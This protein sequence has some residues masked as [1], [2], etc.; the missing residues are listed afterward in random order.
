MYN[1]APNPDAIKMRIVHHLGST[2]AEKESDENVGF[3]LSNNKGGY[4]S[5]FSSPSSRF[6]GLFYFDPGEGRMYKFIENIELKGGNRANALR[7]SVYCIER[8]K[9]DVSESFFMPKHFDSLVYELSAENEFDLVL[10]CKETYDNREWGRHYNIFEKDGLLVV[11]FTKITDSRED[12]SS[13]ANEFSLFLAIGGDTT[14][15]NKNDFWTERHYGF[16]KARNSRP[17]SRHVYN[18]LKLKGNSFVFSMSKSQKGALSECAYV[19]N[20]LKKLKAREKKNFDEFLRKPAVKNVV[21]SNKIG[22]RE[23]LAYINALDSLNK[24]VI[25]EKGNHTILAGLPW[26][27]QAWARDALI[28]LKAISKIDHGLAGKIMFSWLRLLKKDGRLPNITGKSYMT[29]TGSAD[30]TGLLFLRVAEM[31]DNWK[32]GQLP[33][34]K[35]ALES[36]LRRLAKEYTKNSLE[37]N[38]PKETW[39]DSEFKGDTREGARLEIQ[40]LKL[41]MYDYAFKLTKNQKYNILKNVL[42]NEVRNDF[43][44]SGVL[45]DGLGDFTIRPN[46]FIAHYAYPGILDKDE[47][48]AC[49]EETL[50]KIWLG[51]GGFST[52]DRS[53]PL[54]CESSTGENPQSYHRGDSWFWINNLGALSLLKANRHKFDDFIRKVTEA[55]TEEILWKGCIGCHSEISDAK[56]LSS[57]GCFNQAWSNAVY[58]ELIEEIVR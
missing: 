53:S 20:N 3:L 1:P 25:S 39:M 56:E 2:S 9:G 16:D 54:Y 10:D 41:A 57:K 18:A 37:Y 21:H 11:E 29:G 23:K 47:W 31:T 33:I 55:S 30:A 24:L 40:A 15:Y 27:F 42:R 45:A 49:F 36:S 28:S 52:I 19:L 51:W 32:P 14:S 38:S 5:F 35:N 17:F 34:V 22:T 58:L 7:N 13:G 12:Q 26:F 8:E 4:C 6:Q 48:E 44:S 43:W 50:K 46:V